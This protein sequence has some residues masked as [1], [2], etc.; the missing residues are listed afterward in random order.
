MTTLSSDTPPEIERLQIEGL[1][2]MPSWRKMALLADM[3]QRPAAQS[4]LLL[5]SWRKM[6]LLADMNRTVKMLALAGLEWYRMGGEVSEPSTITSPAFFARSPRLG[7]VLRHQGT[8]AFDAPFRHITTVSHG[9]LA[10]R[11]DDCFPQIEGARQDSDTVI[12]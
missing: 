4:Q 9:T 5:E 1:R 11:V 6:A 2:Q 12:Q 7:D 8:Q 10:R 3:N